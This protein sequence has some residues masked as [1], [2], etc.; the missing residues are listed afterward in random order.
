MT[1][2]RFVGCDLSPAGH[3]G[4]PT[5]ANA[6][7]AVVP[8]RL[9]DPSAV[10]A[11]LMQ[12]V[13]DVMA[14]CHAEANAEEP[15][16][17]QADTAAYLRHPP[18]A[19]ARFHWIAEA[20]GACAGFAELRVHGSPTAHADI[21][22]HPDAR[23]RGHGKA[24]LDAVGAQAR[25]R[26]ATALIGRHA[27]D[28]GARFA[29]AAGAVDSQR[30]IRSLLRLPLAAETQPVGGYTVRS[31][32]GPAPDPLLASYAEARNAIND[33]PDDEEPTL[34][35]VALVRDLEAA[36]AR[37]NR[38]IRVTVVLDE[39]GE[40]VAFTELRTSRSAGA[41]A[42]T[43]DTAVVASHRRKGLG[44]WVKLESLGRLQR[45]RPDV[46]LVATTNAESN[47]AMLELNRTVGFSP[48]AVS[49]NSV[50]Q[51]PG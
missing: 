10:P 47:H 44:R 34:W 7:Y 43:E 9:F 21:L 16:R 33:A 37:R 50:L 49:T 20:G 15:Y 1:R 38:D 5:L 14:R 12:G 26:G 42:T 40:V 8:V 13:H 41:V 23:L 28:A 19:E 39:R 45:D 24:L 11:E 2:I 25:L 35:D 27:T 30:W 36:L 4:E 32:V 18:E 17:S 31:W 46:S 29:A 22:V 51:L 48:V 6:Q 3:P